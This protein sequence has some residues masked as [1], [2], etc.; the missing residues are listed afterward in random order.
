MAGGSE[1]GN[2]MLGDGMLGGSMLGGGPASGSEGGPGGGM[3]GDW[4]VGDDMLGGGP[5]GTGEGGG[6]GGGGVSGEAGVVRG[7]AKVTGSIELITIHDVAAEP[8]G[9]ASVSGFLGLPH[10]EGAIDEIAG[11]AE[12]DGLLRLQE[13]GFPWTETFDVADADYPQTDGDRWHD[14]NW[15]TYHWVHQ[16]GSVSDAITDIQSGRGRIYAIGQGNRRVVARAVSRH[17]PIADSDI[18]FKHSASVSW[19]GAYILGF[20]VDGRF[21]SDAPGAYPRNGYSLR[22]ASGSSDTWLRRHTNG[23]TSNIESF[24]VGGIDDHYVRVLTLGNR[25]RIKSWHVD[26]PE[27]E[28]WLVDYTDDSMPPPGVLSYQVSLGSNSSSTHVTQ[29]HLDDITID[30]IEVELE[31]EQIDGDSAIE[32]DLNFPLPVEGESDGESTVEASLDVHILG[33][34]SEGDSEVEA[35]L[36]ITVPVEGTANG[37][38]SVAA[39][40]LEV[41]SYQGQADGETEIEASLEVDYEFTGDSS[42]EADVEGDL[43]F[44]VEIGTDSTEE[45]AGSSEVEASFD[46]H[47]LSGGAI[48]GE[49][50]AEAHLGWLDG[51]A[52]LLPEEVESRTET[53]EARLSGDFRAQVDPIEGTTEI[54]PNLSYLQIIDEPSHAHGEATVEGNFEVHL[55]SGG[56]IEC[57]SEIEVDLGGEYLWRGQAEGESHVDVIAG[58][59]IETFFLPGEIHGE[60]IVFGGEFR[61]APH[62]LEIDPINGHTQFRSEGR[63]LRLNLDRELEAEIDGET[64]FEQAILGMPVVIGPYQADRAE[65]QAKVVANLFLNEGAQANCNSRVS[66][67]LMLLH[68]RYMEAITTGD[69]ST[70]FYFDLPGG[71]YDYWRPQITEHVLDL[72]AETF[73]ADWADLQETSSGSRIRVRNGHIPCG[74][75]F[76]WADLWDRG[77]LEPQASRGWAGVGKE[78]PQGRNVHP[79]AFNDTPLSST[80][81]YSSWNRGPGYFVEAMEFNVLGL[82]AMTSTE[83]DQYTMPLSWPDWHPNYTPRNNSTPYGSQITSNIRAGQMWHEPMVDD[84][85][86]FFHGRCGARFHSTVDGSN[87]V[88][89]YV[90]LKNALYAIIQGD[91]SAVASFIVLRYR[92]M[93]VLGNLAR[94]MDLDVSVTGLVSKSDRSRTSSGGRPRGQPQ[95]LRKVTSGKTLYT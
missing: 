86:G 88:D 50:E 47:L 64:S 72:I 67:Q 7:E 2:E 51:I 12:A 45:I 92:T 3:L 27:P 52:R 54:D 49:S 26:D 65:G 93:T 55:L 30:R 21:T 25:I 75:A 28:D 1:A 56:E 5:S 79:T 6:G 19:G 37:E 81:V 44:W 70:Y 46:V 39:P 95:E 48:K 91:A 23:S 43:S 71:Q 29:A 78:F 77:V 33:G 60:A 59:F 53:I 74:S 90:E 17:Q 4:H 80:S 24:D 58:P 31:P 32:G 89:M 10:V 66:A 35:L 73:N 76:L 57:S 63:Y 40:S 94:K 87:S 9:Q 15:F 13:Q 16:G 36:G 14:D 42:C 8:S 69:S 68:E 84:H 83:D 62:D 11:E 34:E 20:R 82:R 85:E 41:F 38:A 22:F 18:I 61:V